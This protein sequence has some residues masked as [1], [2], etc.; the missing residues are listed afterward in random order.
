MFEHL[1]TYN[2][3]TVVQLEKKNYNKSFRFTLQ[4]KGVDLLK[5]IV[6]IRVMGQMYH[7]RAPSLMTT[8]D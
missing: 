2:Q 6:L 1:Q 3:L 7:K 8:V 5:V 4:S